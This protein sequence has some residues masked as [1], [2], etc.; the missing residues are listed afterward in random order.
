MIDEL[1]YGMTPSAK[2]V[3][4]DRLPPENM[5]YRP[6]IVFAACSARIVSACG[7]TPGVGMWLPDAVHAQQ[8][9]REQHAVAQVRDR[10]TDS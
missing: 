8:R 10:R 3:T 6:N 1:M 7:F 9:E 2:I 5:S 4:R